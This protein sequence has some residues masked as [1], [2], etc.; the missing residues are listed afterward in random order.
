MLEV[1][2]ESDVVGHPRATVNPEHERVFAVRLEADGLHEPSLD[3]PAGSGVDPEL[4]ALDQSFALED[5]GVDIDKRCE[6]SGTGEV[7]QD[8]G[9]GI[10]KHGTHGGSA[11]WIGGGKVAENMLSGGEV[12]PSRPA[13]QRFIVPC[14]FIRK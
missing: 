12:S 1:P 5:V 11:A 6:G 2:V 14:S 10:L 8:K 4:L 9:A 3:L 13:N 7:E